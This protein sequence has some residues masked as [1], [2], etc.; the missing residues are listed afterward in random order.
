MKK[1]LLLA[2]AVFAG[3]V[4]YTLL[5]QRDDQELWDDVYDDF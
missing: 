3:A 5:T 1:L 2:A 4:V